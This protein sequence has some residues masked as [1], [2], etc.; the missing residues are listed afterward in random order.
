MCQAYLSELQIVMKNFVSY[1]RAVL[2]VTIILVTTAKDDFWWLAT[3]H[4]PY[5]QENFIGNGRDAENLVDNQ[6]G[7]LSWQW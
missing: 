4:Y 2:F 3:M 7:I 5:L 6:G 1:L